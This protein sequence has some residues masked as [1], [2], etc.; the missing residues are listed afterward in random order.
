MPAHEERA[1]F[2]NNRCRHP[3]SHLVTRE[4]GTSITHRARGVSYARTSSHRSRNTARMRSA[5]GNVRAL[6]DHPP[7]RR[8]EEA[9][10]VDAAAIAKRNAALDAAQQSARK[11]LATKTPALPKVPKVGPVAIPNLGPIV[12]TRVASGSRMPA[13]SATAPRK[14]RRARVGPV[15][16]AR[17]ASPS[18][19]ATRKP[20]EGGDGA[21]QPQRAAS[22]DGGD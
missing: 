11:A 16:A 9:G 12:V 14:T 8:R 15:R 4:R 1:E 13:R 17:S 21:R 18:G 5:L 2:R 3:R 10:T 19:A 7:R 6:A 22:E 20:P